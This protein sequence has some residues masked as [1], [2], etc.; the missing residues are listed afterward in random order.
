MISFQLLRDLNVF[1]KYFLIIFNYIKL[2]EAYKIT[3][4][5]FWKFR[6][7]VNKCHNVE[8]LDGY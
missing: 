7:L 2:S 4:L 8:L 6:F 1:Y 3:Y 5:Y